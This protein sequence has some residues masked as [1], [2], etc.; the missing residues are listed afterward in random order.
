MIFL[1][2][3]PNDYWNFTTSIGDNIKKEV[4][5]VIVV[6]A[7]IVGVVVVVVYFISVTCG[8]KYI[9]LSI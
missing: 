8:M 5:V 1:I 7:V 3:R 4:V 6:V 2:P 9:V